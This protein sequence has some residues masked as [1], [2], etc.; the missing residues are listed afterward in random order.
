MCPTVVGIFVSSRHV[1]CLPNCITYSCIIIYYI[2]FIFVLFVLYCLY[3]NCIIYSCIIMYYISFIFCIVPYITYIVSSLILLNSFFIITF[4]FLLL[5]A[6]RYH[7]A[8][9]SLYPHL[10]H[11]NLHHVTLSLKNSVYFLFKPL[12][13]ILSE[14]GGVMYFINQHTP[15]TTHNC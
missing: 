11:H 15:F 8:F 6:I 12:P 1:F 3:T 2:S 13:E 10:H 7:T 5:F 14:R 4:A 9:V